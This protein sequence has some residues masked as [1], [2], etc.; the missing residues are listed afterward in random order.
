MIFTPLYYKNKLHIINPHGDMGIITLWSR[1]KQAIQLFT[2]I[3]INLSPSTSRIA[4]LG[5]LYGNGLQQLLRNLLYNPQI[6]YLIIIGQNLSGSREE[7]INFF[8]YGIE[9]T[10]YLGTQA[11]KIRETQRIIDNLITPQSF[12]NKVQLFTSGVL[13]EDTTQKACQDFFETLP[14]KMPCTLPRI[15]IPIPKTDCLRYPSEPR[16]HNILKETPLSA[17]KELIFK[18]VRFGYHNTLKKGVRIELQNVKIVIKNP[19]KEEKVSDYG[20]SLA[21]FETYQMRILDAGLHGH[22]YTYGNRMRGY[23]EYEHNKVDSLEYVVTLFKKDRET[24]HAYISLWDPNRDLPEG[25]GCPCMVS[26]FFRMFDN[27]LTLTATFRTHNA[28]DAWLENVYGLMAIQNYVSEQVDIAS[29]AITVFSHSISISADVLDK[30]KAVAKHRDKTL[31]FDAHGDFAMTID[32]QDIVVIHSH[33]GV[34]I[35]EY[36]GTSAHDIERQLLKDNALSDVSH[37]LYIGGELFRY[38]GLLRK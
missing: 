25:H 9:S 10:D 11:Y 23:F 12:K 5:N 17:W 29:G 14:P 7:L 38:E 30:A 8:K 24:R 31:E 20:F 32:D 27:K 36:R 26:L 16:S 33:Q 3:G 2:S 19:I 37:A 6:T 21:H 13:S 15:D 18:L 35:H 22:S 1:P 34:V 4:V 28:M